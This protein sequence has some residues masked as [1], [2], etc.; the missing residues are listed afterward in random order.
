TSAPVG[1]L[2]DDRID[3][4]AEGQ[5]GLRQSLVGWIVAPHRVCESRVLGWYLLVRVSPQ[6]LQP[7]V[8]KA[9]GFPGDGVRLSCVAGKGFAFLRFWYFAD[10]VFISPSTWLS[11]P[12]T[13]E[14]SDLW[15]LVWVRCH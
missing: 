15:M 11:K 10:H 14:C 4:I 5:V 13:P 1:V 2:A 3:C 6:N 8:V 9:H 7:L 12:P